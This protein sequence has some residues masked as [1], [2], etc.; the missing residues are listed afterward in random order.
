MCA[1]DGASHCLSQLIPPKATKPY[2]LFL[3]VPRHW[4]GQDNPWELRVKNKTHSKEETARQLQQLL[5]S[6]LQAQLRPGNS[7]ET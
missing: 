7:L 3:S 4:L 5:R 1:Q 2:L 6:P